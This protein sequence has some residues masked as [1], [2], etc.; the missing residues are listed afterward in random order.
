MH[1]GG[2]GLHGGAS[3]LLGRRAAPSGASGRPAGELDGA[4]L[5]QS[6]PNEGIRRADEQL[7]IRRDGRAGPGAGPRDEGAEAP[8]GR[9]ASGLP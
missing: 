5:Q 2:I 1:P 4:L 7:R 6:K 3:Q 9:D 8:R